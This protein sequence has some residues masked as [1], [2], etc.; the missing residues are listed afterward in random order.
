MVK[1][2]STADDSRAAQSGRGKRREKKGKQG[3]EGKR[4]KSG[5]KWRLNMSQVTPFMKHAVEADAVDSAPVWLRADEH[6]T[7]KSG[8]RGS[9]A[10][11]QSTRALLCNLAI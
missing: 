1:N 8:V 3:K 5:E 6:S 2:R 11:D 9:P 4:A 7:W 10:W